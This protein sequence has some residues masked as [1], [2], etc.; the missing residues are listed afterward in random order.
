MRRPQ[1]Q[2]DL[3][4]SGFCLG[5]KEETPWTDARKKKCTNLLIPTCSLHCRWNGQIAEKAQKATFEAPL[6]QSVWYDLF[7]LLMLFCYCVLFWCFF[8]FICKQTFLYRVIKYGTE[9]FPSFTDLWHHEVDTN[10]ISSYFL[11]GSRYDTT[12]VSVFVSGKRCQSQKCATVIDRS[13]SQQPFWLE[14]EGEHRFNQWR[15]I[16]AQFHLVQ[17]RFF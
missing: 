8:F 14:K 1:Q 6:T 9:F 5:Q 12:G 2:C 17:Q 13:F 7:T 4:I 16:K 3:C 11:K 15:A 10:T